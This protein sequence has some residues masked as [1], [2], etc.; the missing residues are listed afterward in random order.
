MFQ[1]RYKIKGEKVGPKKLTAIRDEK[2]ARSTN[3]VQ[4]TFRDDFIPTNVPDSAY[5]STTGATAGD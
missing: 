5:I 2:Q 1:K 4:T 3:S